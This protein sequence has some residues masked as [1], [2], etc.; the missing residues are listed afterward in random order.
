MQRGGGGRRGGNRKRERFGNGEN[1]NNFTCVLIKWKLK[2]KNEKEIL[3]HNQEMKK[4][5]INTKY[6]FCVDNTIQRFW[7]INYFGSF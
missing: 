4:R 7:N 1:L 6:L 5:K 3:L 2:E